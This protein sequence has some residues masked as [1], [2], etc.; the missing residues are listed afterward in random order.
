[1]L[2]KTREKT[3]NLGCRRTKTQKRMLMMMTIQFWNIFVRKNIKGNKKTI[4]IYNIT[5]NNN[6]ISKHVK[7]IFKSLHIHHR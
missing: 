4:I 1:M 7:L 3:K 6:L 5:C 2:K